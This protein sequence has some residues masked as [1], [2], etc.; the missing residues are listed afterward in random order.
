MSHSSKIIIKYNVS[1]NTFTVTTHRLK[2][3]THV[4]QKSTGDNVK[5]IIV[6]CSNIVMSNTYQYLGTK[7]IV[8]FVP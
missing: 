7:L 6:N 3:K 1:T 4:L 2:L 5:M 8:V